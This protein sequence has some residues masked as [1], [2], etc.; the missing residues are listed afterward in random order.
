MLSHCSL[1]SRYHG[2]HAQRAAARPA[3]PGSGAQPVLR[4]T[5]PH[6]RPE[7]QRLP[8]ENATNLL[9]TVPLPLL[10]VGLF[11]TPARASLF[12]GLCSYLGSFLHLFIFPLDAPVFPIVRAAN[13]RNR[14]QPEQQSPSPGGTP[15]HTIPLSTVPRFYISF[16]EMFSSSLPSLGGWRSKNSAFA[17]TS[18]ALPLLLLSNL[19]F[20]ASKSAADYYVRSLPGAPE[21]PL[22]KMH[23]GYAPLC[24]CLLTPSPSGAR[25]L[26]GY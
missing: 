5:P 25:D 23:A 11:V 22:L 15:C 20:A 2:A 8:C 12:L 21:G 6:R 17:A 7:L 16:G 4:R 18:W 10:K 3:P 1:L 9:L 13:P 14:C 19:T 24:A 26:V